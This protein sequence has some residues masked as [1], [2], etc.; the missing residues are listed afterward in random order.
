MRP[1]TV[2]VISGEE[3]YETLYNEL[4]FDTIHMSH[5]KATTA[6]QYQTVP[7]RRRYKFSQQQYNS[8]TVV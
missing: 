1:Y 6:P 5:H 7:I 2:S 8:I 3:G 4:N